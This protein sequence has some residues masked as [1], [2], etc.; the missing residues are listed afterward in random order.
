MLTY[1]LIYICQIYIFFMIPRLLIYQGSTGIY[2]AEIKVSIGQAF[3][4]N[5]AIW[6]PN[7]LVLF[8]CEQRW[9]IN[10]QNISPNNISIVHQ[11]PCQ[12]NVT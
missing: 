8:D 9:E 12:M 6:T 3:S 4:E 10:A 2:K 11:D 5:H 7:A 1:W